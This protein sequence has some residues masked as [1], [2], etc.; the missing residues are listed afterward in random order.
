M[1][2]K[3]TKDLKENSMRVVK[4]EKIV[5]SC[6]GIGDELEK[7]IKLLEIVSGKKAAR[8]LTMKRIP[9]F[10]VKPKMN[11]GG[12]V[13]LRGK[14]VEEILPRLLAAIENNLSKKQISE[15]HFSFGIKEYIEIPGVKYDRELGM[16][17][18]EVTIVFTRNGKRVTKKKANKG[19]M[20]VRQRVTKQEIIKYLQD[21][22]DTNFE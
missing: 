19:K 16:R 11:L 20:P 18:F 1:E 15:N 7:G 14:E 3:Q 17:G 22:F 8:K 9:S 4:I 21:K 12:L 6:R 5:L 13:T 2:K 10:G